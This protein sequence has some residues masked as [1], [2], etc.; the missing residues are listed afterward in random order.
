MR[1]ASVG[2]LTVLLAVGCGRAAPDPSAT[3]GP[4]PVVALSPQVTPQPPAT[5]P[6]QPPPAPAQSDANDEIPSVERVCAIIPRPGCG[7]GHYFLGVRTAFEEAV[8]RWGVRAFPAYEAILADATSDPWDVVGAC[9]ALDLVKGERTRFGPLLVHRLTDPDAMVR[10][11]VTRIRGVK[12]FD[13]ESAALFRCLVR[14]AAISLLGE[15]GSERDADH[16]R[17][18]L[19]DKEASVRYAVVGALAKI[20][21]PRDLDALNQWLC[22][23]PVRVHPNQIRKAREARDAIDARLKADPARWKA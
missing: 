5:S 12:S 15:I 17:P 21:G 11:G 6:P 18:F 8:I 22:N 10:P 20:G 23:P 2:T 9:D 16:V 7:C 13:G 14:E 4:P 3:T 1:I 19:A